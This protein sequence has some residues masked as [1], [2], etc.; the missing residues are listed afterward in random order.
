MG[1]DVSH[2]DL[3]RLAR[4]L[5]SVSLGTD[6]DAIHTELCSLR[7]A[8]VRHIRAEQGQADSFSPPAAAAVRR[9]H[10][11][12][13]REIDAILTHADGSDD[14]CHCVIRVSHLTKAIARQAALE[15]ALYLAIERRQ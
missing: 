12:L 7:N 6:I 1:E 3:L 10:Q 11:E 5:Q 13:L 9:G 8:L 14:G 2:V 15:N 4:S